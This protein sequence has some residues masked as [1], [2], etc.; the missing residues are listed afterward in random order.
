[1]Q[2]FQ[3]Y[4]H[5]LLEH[6]PGRP[7]CFYLGKVILSWSIHVSVESDYNLYVLCFGPAKGFAKRLNIVD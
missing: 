7:F 5:L 2:G 1:M 6:V 3:E 4:I